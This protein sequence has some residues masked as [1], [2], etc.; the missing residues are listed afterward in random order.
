MEITSEDIKYQDKYVCILHPHINKGVLVWHSYTKRDDIN[1][2][3]DGIK[4]GLL[5]S[6]EKI[7]YNRCTN[8]PYIFFR[9]PEKKCTDI[10]EFSNNTSRIYIRVDPDKTFIFSSEIRVSY[11]PPFRYLSPEY[12]LLMWNELLKS[13]KTLREYFFIVDE[14]DMV[15][16][17]NKD[18]IFMYNLYTSRKCVINNSSSFMNV[19]YPFNRYDIKHHSEILVFIQHLTNDYFVNYRR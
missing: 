13:K 3:D 12:E 7:N 1:L 10:G 5:L 2:H 8:Y 9:A 19:A 18:E 14:N 4:S 6:R 15:M 17:K 16:G 11:L